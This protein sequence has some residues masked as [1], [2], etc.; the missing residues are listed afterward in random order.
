MSLE[1]NNFIQ[2]VVE[3]RGIDVFVAVSSPDGKNLGEYD[4]ANGSE[5]PEHVSF[6]TSAAGTYRIRISPLDPDGRTTG[7]YEIKVVD[8]RKATE[9]E[10]KAEKH[11][12]EVRA[13]GIALLVEIENTLQEIKS[14]HS[15]I[16]AQ[17]KISGLLREVD[18]KRSA[19]FMSNAMAGIK[20]FL[21]TAD[22]SSEEYVAQ[23][24]AI[25]QL[26]NELIGVL[27]ERDPDMA[28]NF[29]QS[30]TPRHSP[31]GGPRELSLQ[32][33]ALEISIANQ[34]AQKDPNRAVQLARRNL[35]QG[36]RSELVH[37]VS[38]LAQKNPELATELVHEI[39]S[40]LLSE[41]KLSNKADAAT[42]TISLLTSYHSSPDSNQSVTRRMM[43]PLRAG[44]LSDDDYKQL[45]QKAVAD[46]VSYTRTRVSSASQDGIWGLISGLQML[47]ADMD[48]V[49][50]GSKAAIEKKSKELNLST[51]I[52][53]PMQEFQ[54]VVANNPVEVAL[55]S[56]E[57]A[58]VDY[59]EQMYL[60]L[61]YREAGNGD[62]ARAKQIVND[63][64][65][66][67]Y[68]QRQAIRN[69]EQQETFRVVGKGKFEEA[70]RNVGTL[71]NP[72]ERATQ[73]SQIVQH[74]GEGQKRTTALNL[75]EQAR[76]L[77]NPSPQA[78]DTEHMIALFDIARAFS[79]YD[80]KR[81]FEIVDPL[82]DQFNELCA[83]AR[84]LNGFSGEFFED[85]ELNLQDGNG[86]A[87]IVFQMSSALGELA[88]DN[89]DRTKATTEKIRQPEVRLKVYL[90]IA[91]QTIEGGHR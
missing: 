31:Y 64:V 21:A 36:Y 27:A 12:E 34:I 17:I 91:Q 80:S 10:L 68:Q 57:K 76:A 82:I 71:K 62:L 47:G 9:E 54:K 24:Q 13:K 42:L 35:K 83:A 7:R 85:D 46:V 40:K 37:T 19:K 56:I 33:S 4:T 1:E 66:N 65:T 77:L 44:L 29:L 73:L 81:S 41:D 26:R 53:N 22:V 8:V 48:K 72:R 67:P 30:T 5:G 52:D 51:L 50:A 63:H 6:V 38:L 60:Q 61:A 2:L 49:V 88:L 70:L 86:L 45:L 32:E 14:L 90:E 20:E 75:L 89:F 11:L 59:K 58:P 78:P 18:E 16:Q 69:L 25:S 3:Q 43:S 79:P 39:A 15:R 74:I 55:E 87:N 28:L 23:Y 84:T